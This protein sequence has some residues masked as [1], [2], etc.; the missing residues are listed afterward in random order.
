MSDERSMHALM[1]RLRSGPADV[2]VGGLASLAEARGWVLA[3]NP[4][5]VA[6]A[7]MQQS[8]DG[9]LEDWVSLRGR[10]R[11]ELRA[12]LRRQFGRA[13]HHDEELA[14][15]ERELWSIRQSWARA[16]GVPP[17]LRE[18]LEVDLVGLLMTVQCVADLPAKA[19]H[20]TLWSAYSVRL[21]PIAWSGKWPAG[22]LVVGSFAE[23]IAR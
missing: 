12:A 13:L 8:D 6:L 18:E 19:L 2:P 10:C 16:L 17:E 20:W 14:M 22:N 5:Q 21:V 4:L 3:S 9:G 11:A 7:A 1:R 23:A 15:D